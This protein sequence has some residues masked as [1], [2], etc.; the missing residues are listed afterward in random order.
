VVKGVVNGGAGQFEGVSGEIIIGN[1]SHTV[2]D[3]SFD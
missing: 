3:A 1:R 2:E